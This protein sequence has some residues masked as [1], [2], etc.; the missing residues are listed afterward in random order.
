MTI[1]DLFSDTLNRLFRRQ[2]KDT[3]DTVLDENTVL[4]IVKALHEVVFDEHR[5]EMSEE[6][7]CLEV[8]ITFNLVL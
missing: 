4:Y 1:I 8:L 3:V 6:A 2:L 7:G 5:T